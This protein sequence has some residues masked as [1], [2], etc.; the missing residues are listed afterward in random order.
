MGLLILLRHGKAE[1]D[2]EAPDDRARRLVSRGRRDAASAAEAVTAA[3]LFAGRVL[4]SPAA[5][6]RETAE[7]AVEALGWSAPVYAETLYLAEA[8]EIWRLAQGAVGGGVMIVGH[9]PGMHDLVRDLIGRS[10]DRSA[11][12]RS[13]SGDFPTSAWAAFDVEEDDYRS[14][15]PRF[16]AGWSPKG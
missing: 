4:A 7:I 3:G 16:R 10:G 8:E 6:T 1:R 13:L 2:H 11:L 5:R 9:N 12:A 14:V 15:V